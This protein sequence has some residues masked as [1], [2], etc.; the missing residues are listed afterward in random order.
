MKSA[1]RLL[2]SALI[3]VAAILAVGGGLA[4][5]VYREVTGAGPLS[6]A[7]VVVIPPHSGLDEIARLL[8]KEGVVRWRLAFDIGAALSGKAAALEAGEYRFPAGISPLAAAAMIAAGETVKHKLTIPEGLTNAQIAALIRAAPALSGRLG[9]LPPEGSL[10]PD[11]YIYT[12]G[13]PRHALVARMQQEMTRALAAAWA[14]R[15]PGLPLANP[16]QLLILASIIEKETARPAERARIAGV[17]INRL[18]LGMPLGSDPTVIYALTLA[19]DK[20]PDRSLTHA[21]LASPSPYNTYLEK[22]LPPTPIDNPG[23]ASLRAAAW[24]A[25]TDELYF[26][27]DGNGGHVFAKTLTEHDHNVAQYRKGAIAKPDPV[28]AGH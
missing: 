28:S 5:W 12:Y 26:V 24:P 27:A 6:Q 21:D 3:A 4:W 25:Q 17:F 19:G 18:R 22:G 10:M 9:A 11:T 20:K 7:H 15:E 14:R 1:L 2:G 8:A 13:E 23:L 16:E